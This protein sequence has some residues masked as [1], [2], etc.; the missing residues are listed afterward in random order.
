MKKIV[1]LAA[2]AVFVSCNENKENAPTSATEMKAMEDETNVDEAG[3]Y[4]PE[5][6]LYIWKADFDYTKV[7]N[8]ATRPTILNAD[9]LIKG[10]NELNENVFLQKEKISGDTIYTFIEDSKYLAE[11][12][13]SSGAELYV[14]NVVLNLTEVPGVKYV[15]IKIAEGSHAQPGTWTKQNFVKYKTVKE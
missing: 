10:L 15:S 9:S 1:L 12:M 8:P 14:A 6:K 11:Q 2:I 4:N 13:G 7:Q 5:S 3:V